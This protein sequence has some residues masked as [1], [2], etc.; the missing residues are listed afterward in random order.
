M[1]NL[2]AILILAGVFMVGG[3]GNGLALTYSEDISGDLNGTN[4]GPLDVGDNTVTGNFYVD[5]IEGGSDFDVF[6]FQINSGENLTSIVF[7]VLGLSY[8]DANTQYGT[9]AHAAPLLHDLT[10]S[11]SY[12]IIDIDLLSAGS[13]IF[14]PG[15]VFGEGS[16]RL[17]YSSLSISPGDAFDCDYN[18][19]L[20][21]APVPEPATLLLFG[22]GL[23]GL[24]ATR[25]RRKQK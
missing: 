3:L 7:N 4:I 25:I 6:S 11:I 14:Y 24:A 1:K 12:E 10:H 16:Y 19:T 9:Y 13:V 18:F 21:V 17:H 20:T 2:I 5:D 8:N 15:M 22:S 23:L